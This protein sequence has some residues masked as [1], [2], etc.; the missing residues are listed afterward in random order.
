VAS[1]QQ[2]RVI[3]SFTASS[4]NQHL[5]L[6]GPAGTGKT[7][8][9]LQVANNI[10][11]PIV[12]DQGSPLPELGNLTISDTVIVVAAFDRVIHDP[13]M[14][15]LNEVSKVASESIY[16]GWED[17]LNEFGCSG[18]EPNTQLSCLSEALA[19]RWEKRPILM[20]VDEITNEELVGNLGE[21]NLP[22]SVRLIL[23]M[24]PIT[25]DSPVTLP[26]TFL[27][28]TLTT[29]YRS[30]IAITKLARF[31]ARSDGLVVPETEFG[32]DVEG[33]KPLVFAVGG[34]RRKMKD[35]FNKCQEV[36]GKDATILYSAESHK[37]KIK[38]MLKKQHAED[39]K[40]WEC[41][42]SDN[43]FGWE[44]ERVVA[45]TDGTNIMEMITRAQLSLCVILADSSEAKIDNFRQAA[46]E[47]LIEM[48]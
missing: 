39:G 26:L 47:G 46:Q 30:T 29:Q 33:E 18:L 13:I 20:I 7:L 15:Y 3:E 32:S 27:R 41:Y 9:A 23:I 24:N 2:Q 8:M 4:T 38:E 43:F 17:L 10:L 44:A 48:R 35:A 28:T 25:S 19:R 16:M 45:V 31:I 6:E 42:H 1:P 34:N 36:L 22:E 21:A 12:A 11:R 37:T 14:Q 40:Q 5:V